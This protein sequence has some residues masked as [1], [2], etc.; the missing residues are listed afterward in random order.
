MVSL[1]L[2]IVANVQLYKHAP[3]GLFPQQDTGRMIGKL[4]ADQSISFER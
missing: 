4:E 3:K 1:L 2:V